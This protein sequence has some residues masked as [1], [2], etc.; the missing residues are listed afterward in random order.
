MKTIPL[1]TVRARWLADPKVRKAY[2]DMAQEFALVE[3]LLRAR[4]R[5]KLTQAEIA[6]RMGTSQSAVAR[7]ES[8]RRM[9]TLRSLGLYARATGSRLRVDLVPERRRSA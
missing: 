7:L 3:A 1:N 5:A 6:R 2:D 4:R 9:P 8:G